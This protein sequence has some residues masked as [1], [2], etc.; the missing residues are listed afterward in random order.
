ML[1]E[2]VGKVPKQWKTKEGFIMPFFSLKSGIY[3]MQ[4]L[5]DN[6]FRLDKVFKENGKVTERQSI[7]LYQ[8]VINTLLSGKT[9]LVDEDIIKLIK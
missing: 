5:E 6:T 9:V 8:E 1:L 7:F 3:E 2:I 4:D